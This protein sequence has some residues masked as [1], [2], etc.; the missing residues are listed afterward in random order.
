MHE[1]SPREPSSGLRL[2]GG[3]YEVLEHVQA[4]LAGGVVTIGEQGTCRYC[5]CSDPKRFRTFA[6][7]FPE[8]L[9]NK[10]V[11][12]LD[13][14]DECNGKFSPY[15][16]ALASSL[17]PLLTVGG[18][19]GKGNK[20][21][22]T[23]RT[24]GPAILQHSRRD[25]QRALSA[26]LRGPNLRMSRE[27]T[28]GRIGLNIPIAEERFRPRH[29]YKA[30]CKMAFALLPR[31]EWGHYE[32][33]R[34]WLLDLDDA[35]DFP[36]LEVGFSCSMIGNAPPIL[37]AT[38]LRRTNPHDVVPHILFVFVAGSVC[39]YI[40]LRSDHMEDHIPFSPVGAVN[41]RWTAHV[42]DN[43]TKVMQWQYAQPVF[44]NWSS[45]SSEMQP[46]EAIW[47]RFN[48]ETRSASFEL[49]FR[50]SAV[51]VRRYREARSIEAR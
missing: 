39:L 35:V 8:A 33:L 38:L 45:V 34:A 51:I 26:R 41:L 40:D 11:R 3:R 37:G 15:E 31:S 50:N 9:G 32:Q 2:N 49:T 4:S 6:H 27:L 30:L 19:R 12:S 48:P 5:S 16:S 1:D 10:W 29:A 28:T 17:G 24:A 44:F 18:V 7:T 23:G 21:R 20:V 36:M 13:E 25:A 14:C 47:F 22:Q 42:E 43:E 46:I